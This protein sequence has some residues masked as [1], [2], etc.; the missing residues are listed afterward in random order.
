MNDCILKYKYREKSNKVLMR[1]KM[2][3][4]SRYEALKIIL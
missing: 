3:Q 4:Y 2:P 1:N